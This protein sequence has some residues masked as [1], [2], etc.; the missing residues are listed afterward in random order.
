V[1]APETAESLVAPAAGGKRT[2]K[3]RHP[4]KKRNRN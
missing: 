2:R 4:K 1:A 3:R